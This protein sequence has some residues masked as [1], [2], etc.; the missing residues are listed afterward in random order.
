ML[1]DGISRQKTRP[2]PLLRECSEIFCTA[3]KDLHCVEDHGCRLM[4]SLFARNQIHWNCYD[5]VYCQK[6]SH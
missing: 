6:S 2:N 1:T 4:V 5:T 3:G